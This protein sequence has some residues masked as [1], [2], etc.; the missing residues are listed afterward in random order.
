MESFGA[1]SQRVPIY[2]KCPQ[3]GY[4]MKGLGISTLG[5]MPGTAAVAARC[6][7]CGWEAAT[8]MSV[9]E[10]AEAVGE[11]DLLMGAAP[12]NGLPAL[13]VHSLP[14]ASSPL[15]FPLLDRPLFA[16]PSAVPPP[17]KATT[18]TR[19]LPPL[20]ASRVRSRADAILL[21]IL[22]LVAILAGLL[23]LTLMSDRLPSGT[24]A[25]LVLVL[26]PAAGWLFV[27]GLRL[28]WRETRR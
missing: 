14:V 10:L 18:T 6:E 3:C 11:A 20:L 8:E 19:R 25:P 12:P 9:L 16:A 4:V 28:M 13:A 15:A 22:S 7:E 21:S 26:L 5:A 23:E 1:S 24:F 27:R 17:R 2:A